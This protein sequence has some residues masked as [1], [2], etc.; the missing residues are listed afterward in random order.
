VD[1]AGNKSTGVT[2]TATPVAVP[3]ETAPSEVG[4]LTATPGDGKV[5]LSWTEPGDDEDFAKV[6]ITWTPGGT[7]SVEVVKGTTTY[8]VTSLANGTP[9]TFTVKTVDTTGNESDGVTTTATPEADETAPAEVTDLAATNGDRESVLAWTDPTDADFDHVVITWDNGGTDPVSVA[10]GVQT[11]TATGLTNGTEYTFTVKT[12]D[13]TGNVSVTGVTTT[14]TPAASTPDTTP[15]AEVTDLSA[16][17][18]DTESVLAWTDPVDADFDHVVITWDNGGT[19]P[20][21]VA[22]GEETYTA[23]S[24]ANGTLYT[25]TVKAVDAAGN[26]STGVTATATPVAVPDE[27]APAE[28]GSLTATPGDGKVDLSWTEP[29]DEDF[30]KVVITWGSTPVEVTKGTTSYEVTSLTNGTPYTFTVKTVDA[31]GNVS[32]GATATATPVAPTGSVSVTIAFGYGDLLTATG[33]TSSSNGNT[34]GT[35]AK[36]GTV[37]FTVTSPEGVEYDGFEWSLDGGIVSEETDNT[38][39]LTTTDLDAKDHNLTVKVTKD[40]QF[41]YSQTVTFTVGE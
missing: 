13:T 11:Y 3:D 27:T 35:V 34:L 25:F 37:T 23:T 26:K 24:L 15:P 30:A 36:N 19:D 22:K 28:V 8:E 18:G 16:T 10:K 14:A 32:D 33:L 39:E 2:A 7:D 29:T 9:Y 31:T 1:A 17:N 6:L 21:S 5:D 38:Y 20:V 12:A 4:S 40:G 41:H